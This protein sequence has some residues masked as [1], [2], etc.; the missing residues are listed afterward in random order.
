[1][2]EIVNYTYRDDKATELNVLLKKMLDNLECTSVGIDEEIL[3]LTTDEINR[4]ERN[5]FDL[6][7]NLEDTCRYFELKTMSDT[8]NPI[9]ED[10][11]GILYSGSEFVPLLERKPQAPSVKR[12]DY[13]VWLMQNV[14]PLIQQGVKSQTR[15][16]EMLNRDPTG[17]SK[18]VSRAYNIKWNEF[19]DL[20]DC[21]TL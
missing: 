1:M 21:G 14:K 15:C 19:C 5:P 12:R 17:L 2:V 20:I 13:P 3:D 18:M 11:R 8:I 9:I 16:A 6:L 10:L 7:N 4:S